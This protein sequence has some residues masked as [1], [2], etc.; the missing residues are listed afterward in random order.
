[1]R[2]ERRHAAAL[3][4]APVVV[5]LSCSA[6][7]AQAPASPSVTLTCTAMEA[8][9]KTARIGR[10][11]S[12]PVG[13]T[14]P[15]R[16]VLDDGRLQHE[17]VIQTVDITKTSFSTAAGTELNFRDSWQFN[18]AGYELAKTLGLNMVP[19]Y[20]ERRVSGT[21]ASLS[22]MVPDAM[23]E[24]DRHQKKLTP[25]DMEKWNG[26]VLASR[27]FHELI[28]DTDY[29]MT[30]LLITKDWRTWMIDFTRG[31]RRTRSLQEP[32][33]LTAI[34]RT[35]LANLR[36][37]TKDVLRPRIGRWVDGGQIDALLSRRDL[38]VRTFDEQIAAKGEG[39]VLYDLPRM[40]E[41]CGTGL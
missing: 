28:A 8:F 6:P 5:W 37:L 9:L 24:R 25:P 19:P 33:G 15:S 41:A 10:Q 26:E 23:M 34:D 20:V 12:L 2:G 30:N 17:A 36:G 35:L 4:C 38:I 14:V 11:K 18:V 40:K 31:F 3:L 39:T 32:K 13:V 21:P 7:A 22:W 27:V 29:N 1:M 16:A